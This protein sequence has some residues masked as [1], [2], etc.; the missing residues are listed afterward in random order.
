MCHTKV[1]RYVCGGKGKQLRP[2]DMINLEGKVEIVVIPDPSHTQ[3]LENNSQSEIMEKYKMDIRVYIRDMAIPV[4]L[5]QVPLPSNLDIA[6]Q[7]LQLTTK[8]EQLNLIVATLLRDDKITQDYVQA[9]RE[10]TTDVKVN[11]EVKT[12]LEIIS[13]TQLQRFLMSLENFI[14]TE[15]MEV[16]KNQKPKAFFSKPKI[17]SIADRALQYI[18]PKIREPPSDQNI[19]IQPS[20]H[21]A[22]SVQY[23][24]NE[25]FESTRNEEQRAVGIPHAQ[26]GSIFS[27]DLTENTRMRNTH[28]VTQIRQ[29][30]E[31]GGEERENSE[32]FTALGDRSRRTAA[33]TK[34]QPI[35]IPKFDEN[36]IEGSL[37]QLELL[38][39]QLPKSQHAQLIV[40]FL[41]ASSK[42]DLLS[43]AT[44]QQK[45][46]V[47]D[48]IQMLRSEL[49]LSSKSQ[50]SKKLSDMTQEHSESFLELKSRI[51]NTY[52]RLHEKDS[53]SGADE[54][55]IVEIYIKALRNE[56]VR[57]QLRLEDISLKSLLQRSNLIRQVEETSEM[58]SH[59]NGH[60]IESIYNM[61]IQNKSCETCGLSHDTTDCL[62][63]PKLQAKWRKQTGTSRDMKF[64]DFSSR[65][66]PIKEV[67][68]GNGAF[69]Q[70][71]QFNPMNQHQQRN[72]DQPTL[73]RQNNMANDNWQ[74]FPPQ[75]NWGRR[76]DQR[77]WGSDRPSQQFERRNNDFRPNNT[78]QNAAPQR[79]IY[80]EFHKAF[81]Q[82][83]Q[84]MNSWQGQG[85]EKRQTSNNVSDYGQNS[86]QHRSNG[87]Q[88][89]EPRQNSHQNFNNHRR[90]QGVSL[91][92]RDRSQN[93]QEK[94]NNVQ[95]SINYQS[96]TRMATSTGKPFVHPSWRARES[97]AIKMITQNENHHEESKSESSDEDDA[98]MDLLVFQNMSS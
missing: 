30:E 59:E 52:K 97:E 64:N 42:L 85:F 28:A 39:K 6:V 94:F 89:S 49:G 31:Q 7:Q 26:V 40:T 5:L 25:N 43:N 13:I 24:Q 73:T 80:G 12:I 41:A 98:E 88:R 96:Q 82:P 78:W 23:D 63:S 90:E 33:L 9:L 46:D 72:S 11:E 58:T 16:L 92:G 8:K 93:V 76:V 47:K 1:N 22:N 35:R 69:N 2:D 66:G 45:H 56:R 83:K 3:W 75:S 53:L 86:H 74:K 55:I 68:F 91:P 61:M 19:L 50:L 51:I 4:K 81:N 15:E 44:E 18:S 79:N 29:L 87:W 37:H 67:S 20:R 95:D 36:N 71:R 57:K 65:K 14:L 21:R 38:A 10:T 32:F 62:A 70:S 77:P 60:L 34:L 17:S 54:A 27:D 84:H 48:F